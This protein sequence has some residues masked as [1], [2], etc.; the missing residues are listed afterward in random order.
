MKKITALLTLLLLVVSITYASTS[1]SFSG[2]STLVGG[3]G[4][5]IR[6]TDVTVDGKGVMVLA[7]DEKVTAEGEGI[8]V[9][10][11]KGTIASLID[12]GSVFTLYVVRGEGAVVT[13]SAKSVRIYTP[14][15]LTEMEAEGSLYVFSGDEDEYIF[16][17]TSSS[18]RTYDAI[19]GTYTTI[20]SGKGLDFM[21]NKSVSEKDKKDAGESVI[22]GSEI[23]TVEPSPAVESIPRVPAPPVF[24]SVESALTTP[25]EPVITENERTLTLPQEPV[26]SVK[27]STLTDEG[28]EVKAP[29]PAIRVT[30][31]L[32]DI[33]D[34]SGS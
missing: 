7:E 2:K 28:A 22:T 3:N 32:V 18:V 21:T 31:T 15:T 27:E 29:A 23:K 34:E 6:K 25:D 10:I 5:T 20:E 19:R 14:T 16:N 8:K 1:L 30:Q 11:G 17:Y 26:V 4:R 12:D 33:E 9:L 13:T 24:A